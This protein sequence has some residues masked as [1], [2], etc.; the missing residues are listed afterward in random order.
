M[1]NESLVHADIEN[2]GVG[3]L[4]W[5]KHLDVVLV[6]IKQMV[7]LAVWI[8]KVAND[9]RATDTGFYTSGQ[10]AVFKAVCTEGTFISGKGVVID[11][12]SIVRAS[13]DTISTGYAAV[14]C[15]PSQCRLHVGRSLE[16]DK[17]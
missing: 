6:F 10:Q 11:E 16:Q 7:D 5:L 1:A 9:T 8:F 17:P 14:R 4:L 15:R 3:I 13:L 2:M 12:A